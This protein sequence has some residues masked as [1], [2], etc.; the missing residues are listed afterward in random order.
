MEKLLVIDGHNLLMRMYYGIPGPIR[1]SQGKDIRGV[2][3]F[4]GGLFKMVNKGEFNKLL[5]IFDS[6][7]SIESRVKEDS[8]YKQNR[9]D[10]S[11]VADENNPFVQ[12]KYIYKILDYLKVDY[13]EVKGY[14]ADDYIASV[15]RCYGGSHH[16]T[17]ASTDRDFLQLVNDRV[18]VYSPRGKM[19]IAFT[20]AEVY[21][22]L[23]ISPS[24]MVDYKV[25]VGDKSD[26][27]SGVKSIGPKTA[28]KILNK[29]TL[30]EIINEQV[31]IDDKIHQR[32]IDS[33]NEIYRNIR[34]ITMKDDID[35]K[36][37][38]HSM[39]IHFDTGLKIMKLIEMLGFN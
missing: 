32:I 27:I 18:T 10:Y 9:I 2:I 14:E 1:N 34:L 12:L 31:Q 33:K 8:N 25:L 28:I 29:G 22:K 19:S 11:Q 20:P 38:K 36:A 4:I 17:I 15:C 24:Q 16:I 21:R 37:N 26:N 39:E 3:G 6:E 13:L 7:T 30:Q 35:V 5:I 23:K